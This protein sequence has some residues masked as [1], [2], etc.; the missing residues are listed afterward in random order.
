M[1]HD[2]ETCIRNSR[3]KNATLFS[4]GFLYQKLS[5]TADQSNRRILVTCI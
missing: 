4:A 2:Q 1:T 5:N 3:R